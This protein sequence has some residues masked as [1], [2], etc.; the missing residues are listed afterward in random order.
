[1]SDAVRHAVRSYDLPA[2]LLEGLIAARSLELGGG[3]FG[4]DG[5]LRDFLWSTEGAQFALAGRVLGCVSG[6]DLET[7]CRASGQAYG[8]ARLLFALPRSLAHGR[9]PLA[10]TELATAGV[11]THDLLTGMA[12]PSVAALLGTCRAQVRHSLVDARRLAARLPHRTR[13]AFRPLALV[14]PYLR[15]QERVG[16]SLREEARIAPLTRVCRIAAAHVL[17]RP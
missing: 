17:G 4:D 8:M 1:V 5:A 6:T 10:R 9:I 7:A 12:T 15:A 16:P 14:G 2:P 13:I 11:T 3:P